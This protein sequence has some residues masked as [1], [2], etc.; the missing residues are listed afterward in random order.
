MK[1]TIDV[2]GKTLE[3]ANNAFTPILYRQIFHKDFLALFSTMISRNKEVISKARALTSV[4]AK[5]DNG[6][7]S[8]EEFI[9]KYSEIDF[10]ESD[11]KIIDERADLI[12]EITFIMNKQAQI[13]EAAKLV[14]L[15]EFDYYDFLSE[16]DRNSLRSAE[17]INKIISFW[18]NGTAGKVDSKNT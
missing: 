5:L 9:E 10:Q 8:K 13:E 17:I 7:I 12:S 3:L 2:N 18:Q 4:K 1:T 6:E 16:F 15:T 11:L 14:K